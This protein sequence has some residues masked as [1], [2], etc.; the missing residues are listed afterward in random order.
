MQDVYVKLKKLEILQK[1]NNL[2]L[3]EDAAQSYGSHLNG[4]MAGSFG[5]A[6]CFSMNPMKV[7][8]SYGEAGAITVNDEKLKIIL[9]VLCPIKQ[10]L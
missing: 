6:G 9:W 1:K 5:N 10:N 8:P 3:I 2:F 7:F 4:K